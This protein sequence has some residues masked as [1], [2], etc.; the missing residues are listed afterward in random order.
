[1]YWRA[2]AKN[3]SITWTQEFRRNQQKEKNKNLDRSCCG[4]GNPGS[5][6]RTDLLQRSRILLPKL[7]AKLRFSCVSLDDI[8]ALQQPCSL[9][10]GLLLSSS[11]G[12]LLCPGSAFDWSMHA[13]A[14]LCHLSLGLPMEH[15]LMIKGSYSQ[16]KQPESYPFR[17]K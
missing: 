6:F 4:H 9:R 11:S 1:M 17:R 12:G 3:D 5:I 16:A 10:C 15:H 2:N 13:A 7:F 14:S 8:A